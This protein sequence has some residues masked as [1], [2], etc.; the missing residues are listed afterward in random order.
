MARLLD[1]LRD[2]LS[3]GERDYTTGPLGSAIVLLAV[4][5]VLEMSM[6]SVFAVADVFFV[7]KLGPSAV[8]AVGLTEAL[9]ILVYALGFGLGI[10][11][12]AMIARRI[13]EKDPA[14]AAVIAVQANLVGLLIAALVGIPGAFFAKDLLELMGADHEVRA[15]GGDYA[16]LM[17]G[18]SV[19]IL[20]L[21]LN[22]AV[23][24]GAGDASRA[25]RA[26]WIA[27]GINIVLDP[28]LIFGLGP[29]PELG[30]FGA[31]VA[32]SI[33]RGIGVA[34]QLAVLVRGAGNLRVRREHVV[35]RPDI[36]RQLL[37]MS[38]GAIGQ[39]IVETASWLMLV[40]VVSLFGS[41]ALAGYTIAIRIVLF[42]LL[43]AWGLA[44]AAATLVGQNLGAQKPE[45]AERSVWL[46]GFANMAFLA[47][48]SVVFGF[49]A[50]P[51]VSLFTS[52][53][54][55]V[56]VGAEGLRIIGF[57][58]LLYGWG[59][60]MVQAFN[61]AGD[62]TTPLRVNFVCFWLFKLPLA[63]WLS[64]TLAMGPTGVWIAVV[65]SY[66]ASAVLGLY[67]FRRGHW[68]KKT[69]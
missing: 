28:C 6:E 69:V 11:A 25:M 32:T 45:R 56:A 39:N 42:A 36:V 62:T 20:L 15:I 67:L 34:Y 21:F 14:E 30:L 60:V 33:G 29:F 7:A 66:S 65:L 46:S 22:G 52:E 61:G 55:V 54:D 58:Y 50:E 48:F 64:R 23:L 1:L 16:A 18:S 35:L 31:A 13:G 53:A 8:A 3:G 47:G 10:P 26:L 51:I 5:M 4:P 24:R 27:N 2:S 43:P 41:V 19:V 59:M 63:Y 49:W 57:G 68:K 37:E 44:N 38:F 17:V 9:L 40:R 12:T